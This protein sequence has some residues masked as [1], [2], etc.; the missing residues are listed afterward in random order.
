MRYS[1]WQDIA[2]AAK[3]TLACVRPKKQRFFKDSTLKQI[4][5][6]KGAWKAWVD[7]GHPPDGPLYDSKNHW[8]HEV[9][10]WTS[11]L[12][13]MNGGVWQQERICSD[14]V[15]EIDSIPPTRGNLAVQNSKWEMTWSQKRRNAAYMGWP[16]HG[17]I[18]VQD[19]WVWGRVCSIWMTKCNLSTMHHYQMKNTYP[20][21]PSQLR[22]WNRPSTN[23][24]WGKRVA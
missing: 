17:A 2:D 21:P 3:R 24:R 12:W 14:L 22:S 13:W 20:T 23:W 16:L 4:N 15:R 7:A 8:H 11:V 18:Q 6:S 10:E 1:L 5:K 9:K 19:K